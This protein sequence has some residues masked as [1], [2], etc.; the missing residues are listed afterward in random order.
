LR[1]LDISGGANGL[2]LII[3]SYN[4]SRLQAE[5]IA[6]KAAGDGNWID[7]RTCPSG[8]VPLK[9]NTMYHIAVVVSTDPSTGYVTVKIFQA[10]GNTTIV[11]DPTSPHYLPPTASLTSTVAIGSTGTDG[12]TH[13]FYTGSSYAFTFGQNGTPSTSKT[14]NFGSLRIYNGAV[15]NSTPI[16]FNAATYLPAL[17]VATP[18]ATTAPLP[19]GADTFAPPVPATVST[20]ASGTPAMAEWI[21]T[22]NPGD[23]LVLSGNSFSNYATTSANFGKDTSFVTFGESSNAVLSPVAPAA[24]RHLSTDGN[25]AAAVELDSLLPTSAM[26]LIWPQN[27]TGT[28][29]PIAINQTEA[30]WLGPNI[31]SSSTACFAAGQPISVYGRNLAL[32]TSIT[33]EVWIQQSGA[34][35]GVSAVVSAYSPYKIDFTIPSSLTNGNTYQVWVHNGHGGAYG[36]SLCPQSLVLTAPISWTGTTY[37]V[38]AATGVAATDTA[39]VASKL[40]AAG[41][42]ATT[43]VGTTVSFPAGTYAINANL[44]LPVNVRMVGAGATST[45]LQASANGINLV[46]VSGTNSSISNLELNGGS[47]TVTNTYLLHGSATNSAG[48]GSYFTNV[49]FIANGNS[50]QGVIYL[51]PCQNTFFEKCVFTGEG[52]TEIGSTQMF[53]DQCTWNMMFN[54]ISMNVK[55]GING[56]AVTGCT[57]QNNGTWAAGP[58]TTNTA[59]EGTTTTNTVATSIGNTTVTLASATGFTVGEG[60]VGAGIPANDTITAVSGNV[61]TLASAVTANEGTGTSFSATTNS[62]TVASTTGFAVGDSIGVGG[63]TPNIGMTITGISGNVVT[64]SANLPA[65]Y[66]TGTYF[67]AVNLTNVG[68]GIFIKGLNDGGARTGIYYG[69]N[70]TTG[71]ADEDLDDLWGEQ[72]SFEQDYG[73]YYGTPT[74]ETSNSVTFNPSTMSAQYFTTSG[75]SLV[76]VIINGTGLGQSRAVS[77]YNL[78]SGTVTLAAPWNLMPDSTSTI[79]LGWYVKGMVAY[80]NNQSGQAADCTTSVVETNSHGLLPYGGVMDMIADSNTYTNLYGGVTEAADAQRDEP[81]GTAPA[82]AMGPNFFHLITN[83]TFTGCYVAVGESPNGEAADGIAATW[84][85]AHVIRDNTISGSTVDGIEFDATTQPTVG[86]PANLSMLLADDNTITSCPAGVVFSDFTGPAGWFNAS[87]LGTTFLTGNTM[88]LGS[89]VNPGTVR[90]GNVY[91]Y[92]V[93]WQNR[94]SPNIGLSADTYSGFTSNYNTTGLGPVLEEP[95]RPVTEYVSASSV[96]S[97]TDSLQLWNDGTSSLG[98]TVSVTYDSGPASGW[99][100]NVTASGTIPNENSSGAVNFTCGS[101]TQGTYVGHITATNPTNGQTRTAMVTMIV[102]P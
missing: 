24:I 28:G 25:S 18:S 50:T 46:N 83:N 72:M 35:T 78:S 98:W 81:S 79:V 8:T 92:G 90:A 1:P 95:L 53:F 20:P 52:L 37:T 91:G 9:A 39:N 69:N 74:S 100:S 32:G 7:L 73:V 51:G 102:G 93:Y 85:F 38:P 40:S 80:K 66:S 75:E 89:A 23:G 12:V 47:S 19:T 65:A 5:L 62:V 16:A 56:F 94:F 33:P 82:T 15:F 42:A 11:T 31:A 21:R 34:T 14:L 99:L 57:A 68:I 13:G 3:N 43:S 60:F 96:T 49:D 64:L 29:A 17:A 36:W 58:L 4:A 59:A 55:G 44:T 63:A 22:G 61:V 84:D 10:P 2:R 26:Y 67:T 30:W 6:Y 54:G 97:V 86:G 45:I 101:T 48:Q 70:T 77:S 76:A 87:Q 41:G 27:G 88:S 71:L